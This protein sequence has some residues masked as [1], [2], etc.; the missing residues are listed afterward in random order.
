MGVHQKVVLSEAEKAK[1]GEAAGKPEVADAP[2]EKQSPTLAQIRASIPKHCFDHSVPRALFLVVRD[3]A[4][5]AFLFVLATRLLRT[6][7]IS[8]EPLTLLDWAGWA[9]YA[10]WQGTAL[11]GWWVLAHE[12]G[13]GGFSNYR[14]LNDTVGWVLHSFLLVP[15]FSWQYSH[16]KHH[17]NTN[18]LIN[19]ESHVPET[20]EDLEKVGLSW[21]HDTFGEDVFAIWQLFSHLVVGWP[22]YLLFNATGG[23]K[24]KGVELQKP[25]PFPD[26]VDHFRPN[27][28][29]FPEA[30]KGR[31]ALSTLGCALTLFALGWAGRSFG[32][33][34]VAVHY[35]APY[36][37]CNFWLV[38]YT[39]LQHTDPEIP[40]YGD[41]E[42]NFL[43]GA[44]CTIDRPYG[45]FDW[46]HHYIGSTHV[47][48][49]I[50]SKLPCYHAVEAT[51]HLKAFLEPHG[52]YNYDATPWPI[53]AWKVAKTCHC[54][55]GVDGV[56]YYKPLSKEKA[57]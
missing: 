37:W 10:F 31:I 49:H 43:R 44:L 6:P 40:H 17:A 27:S 23:R 12:C 26:I 30:W 39:W 18:S 41:G 46:M 4:V 38:L 1:Q 16:S 53:A 5:I 32:F 54:V 21:F 29:L 33:A 11:T 52:L 7:G 50:F 47:C 55:E 20:R 25:V 48:H 42:W 13:H 36:M 34:C 15:Y 9:V 35:L 8:A 45:I 3:A 19:G 28:P 14:L 2:K 57:Q 22:A 51:A 24:L 56:Q